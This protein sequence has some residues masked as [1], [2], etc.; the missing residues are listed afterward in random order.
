[1]ING[2]L[3]FVSDAERYPYKPEFIFERTSLRYPIADRRYASAEENSSYQM[4]TV[5][6]QGFGWEHEPEKGDI[7]IEGE[8]NQSKLYKPIFDSGPAK[9]LIVEDVYSSDTRACVT[10]SPI[11]SGRRSR[12]TDEITYEVILRHPVEECIAVV[13]NDRE[14]RLGIFGAMP[15]HRD[16]L[17]RTTDRHNSLLSVFNDMGETAVA[18][19]AHQYADNLHED[20]ELLQII[21]K[22]ADVNGYRVNVQSS[23]VYLTKGRDRREWNRFYPKIKSPANDTGLAMAIGSFISKRQRQKFLNGL[24]RPIV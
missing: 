9:G 8:K 6:S 4:I 14:A 21:E 5:L 19:I 16:F 2:K 20:A 23:T 12:I 10:L 1:M 18:N 17:T 3:R 15:L 22:E 11:H 7:L 24:Y 13:Y